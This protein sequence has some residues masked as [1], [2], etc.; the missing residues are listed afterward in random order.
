MFYP[1]TASTD[2]ICDGDMVGEGIVANAAERLMKQHDIGAAA[3][4]RKFSRR[5]MLHGLSDSIGDPGKD[6]DER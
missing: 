1:S 5:D 6:D 4:T 2:N 3:T